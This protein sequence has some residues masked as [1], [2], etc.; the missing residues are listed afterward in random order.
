MDNIFK[1]LNYL[2]DNDT[3]FSLQVIPSSTEIVFFKNLH[4]K[5][6][7]LIVTYDRSY[8]TKSNNDQN[9]NFQTVENTCH[10]FPFRVLLNP[11]R[12]HCYQHTPT[13]DCV[14]LNLS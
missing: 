14:H 13:K 1:K 5:R 11:D 6:L 2:L 7:K 10:F 12:S 3:Y 8:I 4:Q 9:S